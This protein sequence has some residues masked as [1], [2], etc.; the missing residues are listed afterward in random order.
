MAKIDELLNNARISE[1]IHRNK[2][3]EQRRSGVMLFLAII[4]AVAS[5]AAIAYGVYRYFGPSYL[6]TFDGDFDY[7]ELDDDFDFDDDDVTTEESN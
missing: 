1:L 6:N 7:D 2:V 5:V 4:G 3:E